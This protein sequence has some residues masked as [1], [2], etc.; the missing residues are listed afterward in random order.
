MYRFVLKCSQHWVFYRLQW[1][2]EYQTTSLVF[3]GQ[4]EVGC[5]MVWFLN[6]IGYSA[7]E[8]RTAQPFVNYYWKFHA[9]FKSTHDLNTTRHLNTENIRLAE[10]FVSGGWFKGWMVWMHSGFQASSESRSGVWTL[11][12]YSGNL[13]SKLVQHSNG[14]KQFVH[15]MVHYSSQVLNYELIVCN[16][17]GKKFGNRTF[18][19]GC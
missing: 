1:G 13:N 14:P 18:Y 4:K 5:Q 10:K 17:N 11:S 7:F 3:V 16:S 19:H 12:K 2:S 15:R 6:A 9:F 8:Y